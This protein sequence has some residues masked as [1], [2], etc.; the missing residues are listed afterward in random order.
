MP[1]KP[2]RWVGRALDSLRGFPE[3]VR[4]RAGYQ[5]RRLQQ[6]LLPDDWRPMPGV[7]S[8]VAEIRLHGASEHRVFYVAKFADGV[9]VLH[10]FE[11]RTRQTRRTDIELGRARLAAVLRARRRRGE[12]DP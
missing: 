8:G 3:D 11:K 1:D 6:G 10:A 4:R 9:Y 2:L 12:G 5:L 7:G